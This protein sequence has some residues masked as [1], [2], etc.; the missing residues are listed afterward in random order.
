MLIIPVKKLYII[1][2]FIK[3]R[4]LAFIFV[5]RFCWLK[6]KEVTL[7]KDKLVT[8]YTFDMEVTDDRCC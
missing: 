6:T 4:Y 2:F 1:F 3:W 5:K 7:Q 8:A